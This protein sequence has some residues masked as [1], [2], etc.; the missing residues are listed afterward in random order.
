M[1]FALR[2]C[3]FLTTSFHSFH[4]FLFH[5]LR[6][7][8]NVFNILAGLIV[9]F[10]WGHNGLTISTDANNVSRFQRETEHSVWHSGDS[11]W[12][13]SISFSLILPQSYCLIIVFIMS[14]V[15]HNAHIHI[16]CNLSRDMYHNFVD[17]SNQSF[18]EFKL[19]THA[20]YFLNNASC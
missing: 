16:S 7:N 5:T 4:D 8:V 6:N 15:W 11:M 3:Q 14:P 13:C 12:L 18:L 19:N 9:I 10:R 20:I 17:A 1:K 2:I